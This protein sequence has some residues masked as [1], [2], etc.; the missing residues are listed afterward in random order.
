[1]RLPNIQFLRQQSFCL[2]RGLTAQEISKLDFRTQQISQFNICDFQICYDTQIQTKKRWLLRH[3]F[4]LLKHFS[5][6]EICG[7]GGKTRS[8][9]TMSTSNV[10]GAFDRYQRVFEKVLGFCPIFKFSKIVCDKYSI[11]APSRSKVLK[12]AIYK[13]V[14]SWEAVKLFT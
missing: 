7:W 13:L 12:S 1:M 2:G 14:I 10:G 11:L 3:V 6:G 9:S 4:F 5:V 8:I